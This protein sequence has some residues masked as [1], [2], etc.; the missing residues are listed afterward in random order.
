MH[1]QVTRFAGVVTD[2]LHLE[3]GD[4]PL[5]EADRERHGKHGAIPGAGRGRVGGAHVQERFDLLGAEVAAARRALPG[6]SSHNENTGGAPDF[7]P[8]LWGVFQIIFGVIDEPANPPTH[9]CQPLVDRGRGVAFAMQGRGI[10]FYQGFGKGAPVAPGF[11]V[12]EV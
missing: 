5:P 12:Q 3:A 1:H 2:V 7:L 10:V 9:G 11:E 6:H 8:G 4:I